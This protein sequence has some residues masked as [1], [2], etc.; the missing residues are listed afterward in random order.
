[1]AGGVA[2]RRQISRNEKFNPFAPRQSGKDNKVRIVSR[3][4][5][6]ESERFFSSRLRQVGKP[7]RKIPQG[8]MSDFP[9]FPPPPFK[10]GIFAQFG[11]KGS[12]PGEKGH[13]FPGSGPVLPSE[14]RRGK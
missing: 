6:K 9:G 7:P 2:L 10:S 3:E 1:M 13:V 12:L 11:K 8:Q 14:K 4:V 5:S